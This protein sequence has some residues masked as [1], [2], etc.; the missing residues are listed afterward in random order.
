MSLYLIE[1]EAD[2]YYSLQGMTCLEYAKLRDKQSDA[3]GLDDFIINMR[4]GNE[5]D[6]S[7]KY[8]SIINYLNFQKKTTNVEN[9]Q[10]NQTNNLTF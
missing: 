7:K 1:H 9:N 6:N 2:L 3:E 10:G 8:D 4:R 5:N